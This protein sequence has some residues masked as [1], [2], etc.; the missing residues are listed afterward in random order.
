MR[1][2]SPL[3]SGHPG[4][5]AVT[6]SPVVSIRVSEPAHGIE[7][8]RDIE[9]GCETEWA[10]KG[11]SRDDDLVLKV[12][13]TRHER[14]QAFRLVHDVYRRAGLISE[15]ASGMRVMRHHLADGTDVL[16]AKHDRRV[17]FTLT[18]V[19]DAEFGMPLESLFADEV[20]SMR[21]QGLQLAEVSCLASRGDGSDKKQRFEL[22]VRMISLTLQTARRRGVQRLLLAV[23]PRHAKVYQ[24]LFGCVPCS[25]VKEY[26]A[27]QGH[28]AV[29]CMHDF[30]A[31]DGTGYPLYDQIYGPAYRPWQLDGARMC[32]AEKAG[33]E[34]AVFASP[35]DFIPMA[36]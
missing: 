32:D 9:S 10:R 1:A 15:S 7:S 24:R 25:E 27:V 19:R 2:L 30:A 33:L 29:L 28:P 5:T 13:D 20:D 23:H 22:L 12:A 8:G 35:S 6:R 34:Q 26:A 16:V 36:A 17:A 14:E 11:S 4:G 18:L 21:E 3:L 31:L